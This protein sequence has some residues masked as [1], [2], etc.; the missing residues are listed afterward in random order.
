[1]IQ[2]FFWFNNTNNTIHTI[3]DV[4]ECAS[5]P[6]DANAQCTDLPGTFTCECNVGYTGDGTTCTSKLKMPR[7]KNI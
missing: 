4:D 5:S 1:M 7:N 6:C 2:L 3:V